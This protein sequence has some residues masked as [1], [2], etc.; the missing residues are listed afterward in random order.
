L[1]S[2][3]PSINAIL[4]DDMIELIAKN[5]TPNSD[6][7]HQELFEKQV[8]AKMISIAE[9]DV[10]GAKQERRQS[11]IKL[12]RCGKD[13]KRR[14]AAQGQEFKFTPTIQKNHDKLTADVKE[15]VQREELMMH[16][17]MWLLEYGKK[18]GVAW[19][20]RINQY[21]PI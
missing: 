2:H 16:R 1:I 20:K 13:A 10:S 19:S 5:L 21:V 14:A 18:E 8:L 9:A 7:M 4:P 3:A 15:A 17:H 12:A 11:T 6:A